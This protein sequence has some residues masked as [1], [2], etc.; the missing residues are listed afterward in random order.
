MKIAAW[1]A[2]ILIALIFVVL[3]S[4]H[5][6]GF[7]PMP[8]MPEGDGAT[9]AKI[10]MNTRYMDVVK[11]CEVVGG[12]L[13]LSGRYTPLGLAILIPVTVNILLFTTLIM[14]Q[15]NP[16]GMLAM[17]LLLFLVYVHW[18]RVKGVF[19]PPAKTGV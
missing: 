10:L 4:N 1:I 13:V 2:R 16:P 8:P 15:F 3:G 7:I 6:L 12:L 17:A 19:V 11:I 5:W 14:P 18:D 9:F